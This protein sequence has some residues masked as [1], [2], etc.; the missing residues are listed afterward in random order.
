MIWPEMANSFGLNVYL[1]FL[2]RHLETRMNATCTTADA[3]EASGSNTA[4]VG[5]LPR[6][7]A[8]PAAVMA[9]VRDFAESW[10]RR[11]RLDAELRTLEALSD[12]TLRD[13]GLAERVLPRSATLGSL[14]YERGRWS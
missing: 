13:I 2:D 11:R 7:A 14:D 12:E 10:R 5:P 4:R 9:V 6:A 8:L 3:V 1:F